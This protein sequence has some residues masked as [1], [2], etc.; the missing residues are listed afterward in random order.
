MPPQPK[1]SSTRDQKS[2]IGAAHHHV[3]LLRRFA[4]RRA[5]DETDG[6]L[7]A[8]AKV[9]SSKYLNNLIEQD[10]RGVKLR[11]S[12]ILGYESFSSAAITIA[13]IDLSR[14]ILKDQLNPRG[15]RLKPWHSRTGR[16]AE[17]YNWLI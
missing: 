3:G 1:R 7:C 2:A 15:S 10:H 12:P 14:R 11:I 8:D 17:R 13:G 4:S 5:R 6:Q 9:R 16:R